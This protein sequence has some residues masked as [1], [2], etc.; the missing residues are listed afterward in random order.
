MAK[1]QEGLEGGAA[2]ETLVLLE[3]LPELQHLWFSAKE[4][5]AERNLFMASSNVNI[6]TCAGIPYY[7]RVGA[8]PQG[9]KLC[10]K[11]HRTSVRK[12]YN[13]IAVRAPGYTAQEPKEWYADLLAF[14]AVDEGGGRMSVPMAY[15]RWY[16]A[17]ED[18][19]GDYL[20]LRMPPLM[21]GRQQRPKPGG[22]VRTVDHT[23][24]VVV[25]DI[26]R[27]VYI[28]PHPTKNKRFFY[29]PY[30]Q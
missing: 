20:Q 29:N 23:D 27:P 8:P 26:L 19:A 11:L 5:A 1:L 9:I 13:A 28:Q 21:H 18:V 7:R 30:V 14:V 24:L 3:K 4:V 17:A 10:S 15:V 2:D 12:D 6:Y 25:H 22:G 16:E